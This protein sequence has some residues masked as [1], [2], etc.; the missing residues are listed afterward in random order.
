MNKKI[1]GIFT[2]SLLCATMVLPTNIG[3]LEVM[4]TEKVYDKVLNLDGVSEITSNYVEIEAH[5]HYSNQW[6]EPFSASNWIYGET[7]KLSAKSKYGEVEYRYKKRSIGGYYPLTYTNGVPTDVGTYKV[8]AY[9]ESGSLGNGN[10]YSGLPDTNV[11]TITISKATNVWEKNVS[12]DEVI[13]LGNPIKPSAKAKFGTVTYTYYKTYDNGVHND[14]PVTPNKVGK[15]CVHASV[16]GSDNYTA[17]TGNY[18]SYATFEIRVHQNS[19][20]TN[21]RADDWTYGV[22]ANITFAESEYGEVHY[23]YEKRIDENTWICI[24]DM[25]ENVG[26]YRVKAYVVYG[27]GDAELYQ[28]LETEYDEFEISQ[29]KNEWLNDSGSVTLEGWVFGDD[30]NEPENNLNPKFVDDNLVYEYQVNGEGDFSEDV[31]EQAGTHKVRAYI[32][33]TDNYKEL[34][35]DTV[36]FTI[37]K[38]PNK[39]DGVLVMEGW[40]Y[41][42][43]AKQPSASAENGTITKYEFKLQSKGDEAYSEYDANSKDRLKVGTYVI[44]AVV[45]GG[46]NYVSFA[47]EP[48]EFVVSKGNNSWE[49]AVVLTVEDSTYGNIKLPSFTGKPEFGEAELQYSTS[50]NGPFTT[51]EP[52]NAGDY[53]VKAVVKATTN[54]NILESEPVAFTINKAVPNAS[55]QTLKVKFGTLKEQ[56]DALLADGYALRGTPR[57][58][59]FRSTDTNHNAAELAG[60]GIYTF[61]GVYTHADSKNYVTKDVLII[62]HV[63]ALDISNSVDLS[64]LEELKD[65]DSLVVKHD[66][67][68]LEEGKD[69][70]V[71]T[72]KG[73]QNKVEITFIGNY[74][75]KITKNLKSESPATAPTETGNT[76]STSNSSTTTGGASTGSGAVNAGD[77]TN[78]A[79]LMSLLLG[80]AGVV[81]FFTKKKLSK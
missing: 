80:M 76:G 61:D 57:L 64:K 22:D 77:T 21:L 28:P 32:P 15:Y 25:P 47:S 54:Y 46:D 8:V 12:I 49:E 68:V 55:H 74:T 69:Y 36:D 56:I 18:I 23:T 75:G 11:K 6:T 4:R 2:T 3:G 67:V 65:V 60:V 34:Y 42:E 39:L 81:T 73:A 41:H 29:A 53:F 37:E 66:G 1:T 33:E 44:R 35:S 52:E 38:A 40:A 59:L 51:D 14:G 50:P 10:T 71:E 7:N 26:K 16:P 17:L 70:T 79:G 5:S 27:E 13:Y 63:E 20:T 78:S 62:V 30:A 45:D 72:I 24:N 58:A 31:P 43:D 19:W 48:V 9:V